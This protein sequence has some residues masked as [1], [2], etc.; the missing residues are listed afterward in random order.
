MRNRYLFLLDLVLLSV[1]PTLALV[2]RVDTESW[3]VG[4]QS[5]LIR[6]TLLALAVKL[7]L[8]FLFGL[9]RR[10]WRYASVDELIS[11]G[12][13]VGTS[14]LVVAG[15][16]F[17]AGI[18]GMDAGRSLPRSVPFID[19]LL[20]LIVVGGTRFSVRVMA[21][22]RR[23]SE[24]KRDSKAVLIVGAGDAGS[25]IAREMLSSRHINIDPV[26]FVDDDPSKHKKSIHGVPVLGTRKDIPRL[27][28]KYGI[29]EVVIAIP[30]ATGQVIRDIMTLC[31]AARVPSRTMPGM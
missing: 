7:V 3:V 21:H 9:Y 13:A 4:Y 15:L 24:R 11:I 30:T 31:E 16:F 10:Y 5:A 2:M 25:M 17:G 28:E 14:T 12:L 6:F 29:E 27:V 8:F 22:R 23:R 1:T 19:G 26:G 18:L 20:T